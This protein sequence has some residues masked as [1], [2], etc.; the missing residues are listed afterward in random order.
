VGTAACS[1]YMGNASS[2]DVPWF[3]FWLVRRNYKGSK[4]AITEMGWQ[5]GILENAS[6]W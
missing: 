5:Q 4:P 3:L 1:Q 6:Y 2:P